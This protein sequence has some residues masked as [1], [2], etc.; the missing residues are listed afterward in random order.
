MIKEIE[1]SKGKSVLDSLLDEI[2]PKDMERTAERMRLA[3]R[4]ADLMGE[5]GYTKKRFADLMGKEASVISKW[6]SGTHN[7]TIDTLSDISFELGISMTALF[8][9]RKPVVTERKHLSIPAVSSGIHAFWGGSDVISWPIM[10]DIGFMALD[11]SS[12]I[13][14]IKKPISEHFLIAVDEPMKIFADC[15]VHKAKA[16]VRGDKLII[17]GH[18]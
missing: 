2:P 15:I 18:E 5:A 1:K 6:L 12:Y 4:I 17:D 11:F 10:P 3:G 13:S 7:F 8:E 16:S 14:E 9:E